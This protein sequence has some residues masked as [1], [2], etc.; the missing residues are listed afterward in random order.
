MNRMRVILVAALAVG[1]LVGCAPRDAEPTPPPVA[2]VPVETPEPT[3]EPTKPQVSELVLTTDG[4]DYLKIGFPVEER[5]DATALAV[6]I[7]DH[8]DAD[9]GAKRSAW[10]PN[11]PGA[12]EP[13]YF[14]TAGE[15]SGAIT[16]IIANDPSI[17]TPEGI[18]VGSTEAEVLAAYPD[19]SLLTDNPWTHRYI[20]DGD[21]G[22]LIIEVGAVE[23]G[24]LA[25]GMVGILSVGSLEGGTGGL[26]NSGAGAT[27]AT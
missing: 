8:C 12:E 18:H 5:P 1:M 16:W 2:E 22:R 9:N 14:F 13:F 11:Y 27:C 3:P 24:D 26:A 21:A 17:A 10:A 6:W 7:V 23:D 25:E 4:L 19:A 15:K 20:V